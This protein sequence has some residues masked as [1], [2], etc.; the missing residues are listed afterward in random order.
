MCSYTPE[1]ACN[2][3]LHNKAESF[4]WNNLC[5]V[6]GDPVYHPIPLE[7]FLWFTKKTMM[8][9]RGLRSLCNDLVVWII[10]M[11]IIKWIY[12]SQ[13]N[14]IVLTFRKLESFMLVYFS[15]SK[16]KSASAQS[17]LW[18]LMYNITFNKLNLFDIIFVVRK[19]AKII[20]PVVYIN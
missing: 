7:P 12:Y 6:G 13:F 9:T 15:V 1:T 17:S 10:S 3:L 5:T 11:L 4:P 14:Q 19:S 18:T 8:H 20:F 2:L 16:S